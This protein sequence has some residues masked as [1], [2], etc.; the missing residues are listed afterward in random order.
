MSDDSGNPFVGLFI[1]VGISTGVV[2]ANVH[3]DLTHPEIQY[4]GTHTLDKWIPI[5]SEAAKFI[6]VEMPILNSRMSNY[7]AL[8][9]VS[10]AWLSRLHGIAAP[11]LG[12]SASQWKTSSIVLKQG[13]T[14]PAE[15]DTVHERDAYRI[16]LYWLHN[17]IKG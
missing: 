16:A 7:K 15:L 1:D 4:R 11:L 10:A 12:V 17:K 13:K 5:P 14:L 8:A 9:N 6:V 3:P 2:I